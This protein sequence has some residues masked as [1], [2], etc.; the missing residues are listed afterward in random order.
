MAMIESYI[1]PDASIVCRPRGEL[2]WMSSL[3]LRHLLHDVLSPGAKVVIDL[4]RVTFI[5]SVALSA[6]VGAIRRA[7][8]LGATVRVRDAGSQV[9]R[10]IELAGLQRLLGLESDIGS[11]GH[12][13]A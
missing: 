6:I 13:A 2:D 12:G 9:R 8:S 3:S 7:A 11:P 5:D 10:M 4:S 1:T